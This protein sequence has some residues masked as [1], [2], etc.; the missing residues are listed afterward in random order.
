MS[1]YNH[2]RI[3]FLVLRYCSDLIAFQTIIGGLVYK[4]FMKE[5]WKQIYVHYEDGYLDKPS[6]MP[7]SM[8]SAPVVTQIILFLINTPLMLFTNM[9]SFSALIILIIT[10]FATITIV[11]LVDDDFNEWFKGS[12]IYFGGK[13]IVIV[14]IYFLHSDSGFRRDLMFPIGPLI[15]TAFIFGLQ[16]VIWCVIKAV[17]RVQDR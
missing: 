15:L 9:G 7:K 5:L 1:L 16:F 8:F 13:T 2:S 4:Y 10:I 11:A 17:K 6:H 12:C 3:F 14:L